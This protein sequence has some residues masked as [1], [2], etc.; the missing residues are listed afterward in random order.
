M[1][2]FKFYVFAVSMVLLG[3]F[4]CFEWLLDTLKSNPL[5]VQCVDFVSI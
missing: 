5:K 4:W 3:G 2:I 1:F